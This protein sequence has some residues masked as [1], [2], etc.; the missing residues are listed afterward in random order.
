MLK[1]GILQFNIEISN[2]S[3]Y[4]FKMICLLLLSSHGLMALEFDSN[5]FDVM[6]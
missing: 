3:K 4:Y 2:Y 1:T 5:N 6:Y